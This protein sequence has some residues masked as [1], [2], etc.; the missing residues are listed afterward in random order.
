[1]CTSPPPNFLWTPV[2]FTTIIYLF[3][4]PNFLWTPVLLVII[5]YLFPPPPTATFSEFPILFINLFPLSSHSNFL[6]PLQPTQVVACLLP[7]LSTAWSAQVVG[8]LMVDSASV[9]ALQLKAL[10][11]WRWVWIYGC[12]PFSVHLMD[13][14]CIHT[15]HTVGNFHRV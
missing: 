2:S 3:P 7:T 14:T 1:M 10:L 11:P 9:L 13:P 8:L 6:C 4:Y 12:V 15:Y 5:M